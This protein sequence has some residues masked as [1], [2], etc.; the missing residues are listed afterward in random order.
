[1]LKVYV[2]ASVDDV[3]FEDAVTYVEVVIAN[4]LDV[5][6]TNNAVYDSSWGFTFKTEVTQA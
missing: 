3:E 1:M 5:E 6:Y 4:N 2:S